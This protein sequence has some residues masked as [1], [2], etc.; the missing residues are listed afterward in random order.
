MRH[1]FFPPCR[2]NVVG[3]RLC[4]D[5]EL[6]QLK[7]SAVVTR[8]RAIKFRELADVKLP[9]PERVRRQ[10]PERLYDVEVLER[11]SGHQK[12]KIHYIGYSSRYD[13]WRSASE[14]VQK[15]HVVEPF[16]LHKELASRIKTSLTSSRKGSPEVKV[17]MPFD[18]GLFEEGLKA[19]GQVV[20]KIRGNVQYSISSYADLDS[21]LGKNWHLRGFNPAGDCCYPILETIRFYIRQRRPLVEYIPLSKT[22]D[23]RN[24]QRVVKNQGYVLVFAF[25]RADGLYGNLQSMY[26]T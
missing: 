17:E 26:E 20:G 22:Q 8:K 25:V 14:V 6:R 1:V 16:S 21:V 4:A 12:I 11:D 23:E 15:E 24:T 9:K 7:M 19:K 5:P 13:E 18:R 2:R 10:D 3:G